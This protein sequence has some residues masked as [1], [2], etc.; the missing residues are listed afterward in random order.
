MIVIKINTV[1]YHN[2]HNIESCIMDP[3]NLGSWLPY[4][5]INS[6]LTTSLLNGYDD[7]D[8][9]N[10]ESSFSATCLPWL[11]SS[12]NIIGIIANIGMS[13]HGTICSPELTK[14]EI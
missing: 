5:A 14:R 12:H 2:K 9:D 1:Y 7:D 4:E 11:T 3:N 6:S 13:D 10:I 8:D